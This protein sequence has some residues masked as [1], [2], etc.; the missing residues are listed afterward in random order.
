MNKGL[1]DGGESMMG[2]CV[3]QIA[4][5]FLAVGGATPATSSYWAAYTPAGV[6][7]CTAQWPATE[8]VW[9][10]TAAGIGPLPLDFFGP[11]N[12]SLIAE[13]KIITGEGSVPGCQAGQ[14]SWA[15]YTNGAGPTPPGPTPP[16]PTPPAPSPTPP[17]PPGGSQWYILPYR[18]SLIIGVG[19]PSADVAY[20]ASGSNGAGAGVLKTEDGGKSFVTIPINSVSFVMFFFIIINLCMSTFLTY[21]NA[22]LIIFAFISRPRRCFFSPRRPRRRTQPL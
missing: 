19:T 5:G 21:F 22:L 16:G 1:K 7:E 10:G 20:F 4:E 6:H 3:V 18:E 9:F 17:T 12:A 13:T 11:L 14:N 2:C 8:R 15:I